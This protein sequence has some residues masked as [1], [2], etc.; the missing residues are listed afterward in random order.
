MNVIA[1][2]GRNTAGII[3]DYLRSS[4]EKIGTLLLVSRDEEV[5]WVELPEGTAEEVFRVSVK[6]F[7]T[8]AW[9][10][11]T[12]PCVVVC[13]DGTSAFYGSHITMYAD[14]TIET[15]MR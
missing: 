13:N 6:E 11:L 1:F 2:V 15:S 7:C 8:Q 9:R 5:L 12:G 3:A 10:A 14:G 4:G